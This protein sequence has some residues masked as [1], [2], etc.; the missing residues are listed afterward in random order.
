MSAQEKKAIAIIRAQ[1]TERIVE[2]F[3]MLTECTMEQ[4]IVR[5]WYMDE[6]KR[7]S[8]EAYDA[9]LDSWDESPKKYFIA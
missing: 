3:D 4:A 8:P 9:W 7:R 1:S 2:Q 6:L 5:G